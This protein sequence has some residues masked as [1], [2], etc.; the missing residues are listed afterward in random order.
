MFDEITVARKKDIQG[1]DILNIK[2][3]N[4]RDVHGNYINEPSYRAVKQYR[5][6]FVQQVVLN[7]G[8]APIDS[9]YMNKNAPIFRKQ[10][11]ARPENTSEYWM[12]TPLPNLDE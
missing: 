11:I 9:L 6:F 1:A 12:N 5:E 7:P 2:I 10:P 4:I 3:E 8:A